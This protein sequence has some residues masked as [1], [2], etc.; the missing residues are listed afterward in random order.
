[1]KVFATAPG[2]NWILDR[3]SQEWY[4]KKQEYSTTNILESDI[5][6]LIDGYSWQKINTN[7]LMSKKVVLTVHHV[8]PNKFNK[9][10][11]LIR[12]QFVDHYHV[13]CEQ[14]KNFIKEH[15]SKPITVIGYWYN[16]KCW[17]ELNKQGC[18]QY[19][20]LPKDD[21]IIGSFQRDTE[22]FDLKTPKLEKGPDLFCDYVERLEKDNLH[23]LLGGWRRQYVISRLEQA[24]IKYTYKEMVPLED[25]QKMYAACDLYLVS[26][27]YEGGPQSLLEAPAMKVPI[28]STDMGMASQTLNKNCII[29]VEKEIYFPTQEDV[30][31]N[32]NNIQ[33]FKLD[34]HIEKYLDF[35]K[36]L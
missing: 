8:T 34:T 14:T 5:I 36:R 31:E 1:M 26:S 19:L 27:R 24:G 16:E 30:E 2:E 22:G 28:V 18:R 6:W 32:Y 13:P 11:F 10:D 3:I 29:D 9:Q 15:T 35:F 20:G 25:V 33:Q 4:L 23:I 17:Y 12:D 21:Y 7:L